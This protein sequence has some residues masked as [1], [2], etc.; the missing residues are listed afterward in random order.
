MKGGV[1]R[2]YEFTPGEIAFFDDSIRNTQPLLHLVPPNEVRLVR[3]TRC[4]TK[5]E[6]FDEF[7]AALQFPWYF[8]HNWDAFDE[9]LQDLGEW[10]IAAKTLTIVLTESSE[11]LSLEQDDRSFEIFRRIMR[12]T[13]QPNFG[14]LE[15]PGQNSSPRVPIA[16]VLVESADKVAAVT[17]R[18][19]HSAH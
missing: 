12:Q 13:I 9:C 5:E 11:V 7:S 4:R 8:G 18:W 17:G 14:E 6:L 3:G 15:F 16:L 2:I 19:A 1:E 10:M